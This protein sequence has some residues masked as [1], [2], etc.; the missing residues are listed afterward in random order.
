MTFLSKFNSEESEALDKKLSKLHTKWSNKLALDRNNKIYGLII[1]NRANNQTEESE[2]SI[3][4]QDINIVIHDSSETTSENPNNV[5]Q[6]NVS[7]DNSET[8]SENSINV[9]VNG[10]SKKNN[11]RFINR[12]KYRRSKQRKARMKINMVFNFSTLKLSKDA[13]SLLNKG[14]NFCPTPDK[15]NT[16]QISADLF[17]MD[18][19][20]GWKHFYH[21]VEQDTTEETSKSQFPFGIN[22][23]TNMPPNPPFEIKQMVN[24]VKSDIFGAKNDTIYSNLS[25]GE[26]EAHK[27][28]I[29]LQKKG[30]I[31]IQPAD[32]GSGWCIIDRQDYIYMK[33]TD[34]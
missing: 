26:K 13:Q 34:N 23:K 20:F 6:N 5:S 32:K 11:R 33:S 25:K 10:Q 21:G 3:V 27:E 16:T 29:D 15:I 18:R 28:L 14:L 9:S 1:E 19:K 12:N 24:N 17:R 8:A 31:V 4:E 22:K 2:E 30:R 7:L